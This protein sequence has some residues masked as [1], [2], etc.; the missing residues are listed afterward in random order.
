MESPPPTLVPYSVVVSFAG[1]QLLCGC[2][3]GEGGEVGPS[4]AGLVTG[5]PSDYGGGGG[6]MMMFWLMV[7]ESF[8]VFV[9]SPSGGIWT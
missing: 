6:P 9:S 5:Q 7:T 8:A 2:L 3:T 1:I 4:L